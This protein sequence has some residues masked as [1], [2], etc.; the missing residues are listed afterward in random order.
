M[1]DEASGHDAP[2]AWVRPALRQAFAELN[3]GRPHGAALRCRQILDAAPELAEAHF[4]VGLTALA[5]NDRPTAVSAF[6]SVTRLRPRHA[7]AWAQ[8]ARLFVQAGQINRADKALAEAIG[9]AGDD[10]MVQDLIG[11]TCS[12]MGDQAAA[13]QWYSKAVAAAPGEPGFR[14]NLANALT[15]LGRT[16]EAHAE[17]ERVLEQQPHNAQAHWL[18]SGVRKADDRAHV[19]TLVRLIAAGRH[20]EHG[21]AFLF[22][23]LGKELEDL[24][25]WPRAFEAFARG[26]AARRRTLEFDET[27]E[28][29]T[30]DAL[31]EVFTPEWL[32][33]GRAAVADELPGGPAPVF[34]VGQPRTGTTL[35]ERIL[36]AHSRV[37]S[38]GELQQLGLSVRRLVN[39][40][41]A[42][43]FSAELV[44]AAARLDG[45]TLGRAYLQ[46]SR[47][48]A[49]AREGHSEP[50]WFVDKLPS[51]FLYVPLILKALPQAKIVHVVRDP[52]DA[53]FASFKQLFADAY[54]HSYDLEEM[55][56]HFVRYHRLMALWRE[57]FPGRFLDVGYETV[58]AD[59]LGEAR[60]LLDHLAL[61]WEDACL[62]FHRQPGAVA[63]A[64]AVQVREPAHTRSVGRWRRYSQQLTPVRAILEQAGIPLVPV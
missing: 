1:T 36:A 55:A 17:L 19:E 24:E 57:R 11:L 6:G 59:L 61:P 45:A 13:F 12:L 10:P 8:L 56:R 60:R 47:P 51:N 21:R 26:A 49:G 43:R 54:P 27:V 44:R 46:A 9:H 25:E 39:Y 63:T 29:R 62:E 42:A 32:S 23:A 64:S 34:V 52:M 16:R 28:Q 2:A 4:L 53:C 15:F 31:A 3:A 48:M 14:V 20:G 58:V 41:G 35:V 5:L 30:Y 37:H 18:L 33:D 50:S 40:R 38:A 7:A 22:Y